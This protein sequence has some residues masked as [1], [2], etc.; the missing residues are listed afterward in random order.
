MRGIRLVSIAASLIAVS[1]SSVF[2]IGGVDAPP[3]A[4]A[5]HDVAFS[6]PKETRLPNGLRVVVVERP[7]LPLLAAEVIVRSGAEVDAN[8]LAGTASMTGS[9]LTRGTESMSAP[10]IA[11]AIESLG[12]TIDSG[13][14]WERSTA[15]IVVMSDKAEAALKILSDVVLHP[16]FKQEEI[17]RLKNQTLDGLRVALRQPGA[18]AQFVASREACASMLACEASQRAPEL[19]EPPSASMASAI[20]GALRV[21][22]PFVRSDAVMSARPASWAGSASPPVLTSRRAAASG[23]VWRSTTTTRKPFGSVRSTGAGN[24]TLRGAAGGGGVSRGAAAAGACAKAAEE[25][26][27]SVSTTSAS[28]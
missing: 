28:A 27:A 16:T 21:V 11:T 24:F 18:L 3:P 6:Q 7:G 14:H 5:P 15:T 9:L 17:E 25:S 26:S 1:V 22:V 13:A 19:I 4:S 10:E 12:G 23:V 2:A 20:S 8:D